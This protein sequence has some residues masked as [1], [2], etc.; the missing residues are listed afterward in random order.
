MIYCSKGNALYLASGLS[1][2]TVIVGY[3]IITLKRMYK[4]LTT[5]CV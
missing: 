4:P 3:E 2:E 5:A 1:K